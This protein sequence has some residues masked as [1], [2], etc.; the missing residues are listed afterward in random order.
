M[1]AVAQLVEHRIV[2][3]RVAGSKPVS[4]PNIVQDMDF[5]NFLFINIIV[6]ILLVVFFM[7]G[8]SSPRPSKL[9]LTTPKKI[10]SKQTKE[11][12]RPLTIYFT[13]NGETK[14]AYSTLNLPAGATLKMAEVAYQKISKENKGN[15]LYLNAI[16]AIRKSQNH[17]S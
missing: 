13:Y 15:T 10:D 12:H 8:R 2:V 3:P 5:N 9:K 17:T 1:V 16:Q 14:E 11:D 4:H 6:V 7:R